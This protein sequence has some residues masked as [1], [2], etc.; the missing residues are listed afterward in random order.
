MY[1]GR[2]LTGPDEDVNYKNVDTLSVAAF[3]NADE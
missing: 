3:K 1:V 2:F